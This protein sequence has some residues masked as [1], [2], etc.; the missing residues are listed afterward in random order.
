MKAEDDGADAIEAHDTQRWGPQDHMEEKQRDD[1][2]VV[3]GAQQH[4]V[5]GSDMDGANREA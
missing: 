1:E 5:P 3:W 2:V 4:L